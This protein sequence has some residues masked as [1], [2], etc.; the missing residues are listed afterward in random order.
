MPTQDMRVDAVE[1]N[2]H[3]QHMTVAM[4]NII[5]GIA[6]YAVQKKEGNFTEEQLENIEQTD[7]VDNY[8]RLEPDVSCIV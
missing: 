7:R 6:D 8:A 3:N 4:N 5:M 1:M 2:L